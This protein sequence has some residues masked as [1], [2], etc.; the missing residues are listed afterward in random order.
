M[1]DLLDRIRRAMFPEKPKRPERLSF[2]RTAPHKEFRVVSFDSCGDVLTVT[3]GVKQLV[4]SLIGSSRRAFFKC[5]VENDIPE[6]GV[7][8]LIVFVEERS[9]TPLRRRWSFKVAE[10]TE[11]CHKTVFAHCADCPYAPVERCTCVRCNRAK[12]QRTS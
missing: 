7:N 6:S 4:V 10:R 3:D 1:S 12:A 11:C 8:R 9:D 2:L 5:V